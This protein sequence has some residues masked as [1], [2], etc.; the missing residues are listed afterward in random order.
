LGEIKTS[1]EKMGINQ[2]NI[3]GRDFVLSAEETRKK[4]GLRDGGE[5]YLFFT[6]KE[7]MKSCFAT[8]KMG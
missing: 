7:K 3:S 1:L 6:G 8:R 2:A 4:L 5:W